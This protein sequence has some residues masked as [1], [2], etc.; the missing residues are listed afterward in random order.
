MKKDEFLGTSEI[1]IVS[2]IYR[3]SIERI[4]IVDGEEKYRDYYVSPC[5]P[6]DKDPIRTLQ[7]FL[8]GE[9]PQN[10]TNRSRYSCDSFHTRHHGRVCRFSQFFKLISQFLKIRCKQFLFRFKASMQ[11]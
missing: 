9:K 8:F 4:V 2:N 3:Q 5:F 1:K 7:M 10:R 6:S 11:K